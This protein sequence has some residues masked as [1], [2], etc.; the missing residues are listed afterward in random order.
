[1]SLCKRTLNMQSVTL[2]SLRKKRLSDNEQRKSVNNFVTGDHQHVFS[3]RMT[4]VMNSLEPGTEDFSGGGAGG[5][6]GSVSFLLC[7]CVLLKPDLTEAT[8]VCPSRLC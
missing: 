2:A 7:L 5:D 4:E 6:Q 3:S 1:M 8:L